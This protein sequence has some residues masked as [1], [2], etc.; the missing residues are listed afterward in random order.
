MDRA[1]NLPGHGNNTVNGIN[2]AYKRSLKKM[3]PLGK[4]SSNNT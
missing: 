4:L 3:K 2:A 1:I